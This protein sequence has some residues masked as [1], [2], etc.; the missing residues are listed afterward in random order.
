MG[1]FLK[2]ATLF[3]L[4][5]AG[6]RYFNAYQ[7]GSKL[8]VKISGVMAN[9]IS[10]NNFSIGINI[11]VTNTSN[12]RIT[13]GDSGLKCY[14][15]GKYVG[16]AKIPY[17]QI[18][19]PNATTKIYVVCDVIYKEM[20]SEWWNLFIQVATTVKLT[21]AGSLKFNG[22]YVPIPAIDIKEFSMSQLFSK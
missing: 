10:K 8:D 1:E 14:I 12:E 2:F 6:W 11:D 7:L 5:Y 4:G 21:V 17:T 16:L 9:A 18:I 13:V 15:N 22:V 19:M 20:F 3:V